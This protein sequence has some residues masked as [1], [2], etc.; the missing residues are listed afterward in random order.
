MI[1]I[2]HPSKGSDPLFASSEQLDAGSLWQENPEIVPIRPEQQNEQTDGLCLTS[3]FQI[4]TT[5]IL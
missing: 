2:S 5:H 4:L 1:K 3:T